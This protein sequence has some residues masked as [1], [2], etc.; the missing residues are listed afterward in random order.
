M[1]LF[2]DTN[3]FLSFYHLSNDDLEE[4]KKLAVLVSQKTVTLYVTDQV[5]AEFTRNREA[6]IADAV[7]RLKDQQLNL[8]FPQMCKDYVE[9]QKLRDLQKQY[10]Q[11]HSQLLLKLQT[12]VVSKKLR[13]DEIIEQLF[14]AATKLETDNDAVAK[15]RLRVDIGNPP[16]KNGSLGDAL[17]WELLL[18][19]VPVG[20]P[21]YFV[22]EDR[23]YTSA[24]DET[25]FKDFLMQE[26]SKTKEEEVHFF[27]RLSSFFKEKFPDIKLASELEKDLAIKQFVTSPNFAFTHTYVAKLTKFS[28]FTLSQ[29]STILAAPLSN[30]Q[31]GWIATDPDVQNFR[32]SSH[33]AQR[34]AR[35]QARSTDRSPSCTAIA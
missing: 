26:W 22:T 25:K 20:M 16:G 24:L 15:A 19:A 11:A 3:I 4:L 14:D 35:T 12:D 18:K 5:V 10:D 8:H 13:A 30:N 28:D 31:V 7:K 17:N 27:K 21:I 9:Y 6:K 32:V 1:H 33:S 34:Q 29:A 23:D 2:I